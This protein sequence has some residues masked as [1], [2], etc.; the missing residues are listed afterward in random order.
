M[1]SNPAWRILPKLKSC[2]QL[3]VHRACAFVEWHRRV[4]AEI[5]AVMLPDTHIPLASLENYPG[6]RFC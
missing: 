1:G 2:E 5:V 3:L 6:V 4:V